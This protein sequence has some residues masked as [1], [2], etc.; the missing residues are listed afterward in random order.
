MV[1]SSLKYASQIK[2]ENQTMKSSATERNELV[3]LSG[4]RDVQDLLIQARDVVR[5]IAE[6]P[7]LAGRRMEPYFW[8]DEDVNWRHDY[9]FQEKIRRPSDPDIAIAVFI[10]GERL[11]QPLPQS[12]SLP[13]EIDLPEAVRHGTLHPNA[14][15]PL[16]GT[17]FEYL[18]WR[19][20]NH[21]R[22]EADKPALA[23]FVYFLGPAQ[24]IPRT[25]RTRPGDRQWGFKRWYQSY[26]NAR[27]IGE[28][29]ED[30]RRKEWRRQVGWLAAFFDHFIR[31]EDPNQAECKPYFV[32]EDV[33]AF[34]DRFR[35]H[36]EAEMGL[37]VKW[38]WRESL[39]GL[40]R[41]EIEHRPVF[42]GRREK[43]SEVIKEL[44]RQDV[45]EGP[46]ASVRL[47]GSSGSGKS[48]FLRAEL[49]AGLREG[50]FTHHGIFSAF[51]VTPR[52]LLDA[53]G[54]AGDI[55]ISLARAIS[56]RDVLPA[57]DSR[58]AN[59]THLLTGLA[60]DRQN[61]VLCHRTQASLARFKED[62]WKQ[63][64]DPP[65]A[66]L[67]ICLDQVEEALDE[68]ADE[69]PR[70]PIW[71]RLFRT[72][73]S[74]HQSGWVWTVF[75]L[76]I[77]RRVLWEHLRD[78]AKT[79]REVTIYSPD[80]DQLGRIIDNIGAITGLPL[81]A[82]MRNRLVHEAMEFR[83]TPDARF[84]EDP[85]SAAL[86]L[87]S[88]AL[89]YYFEK[90][91]RESK[92]AATRP[93]RPKEDFSKKSEANPDSS[94]KEIG[95][96]G[97]G[98]VIEELGEEAWK[99]SLG[100]K[101]AGS[102]DPPL[103]KILHRLVAMSSGT[104]RKT[105]LT[106]PAEVFSGQETN[107]LIQA[108]VDRRLALR[109]RQGDVRLV[110][111]VVLT[112]WGRARDWVDREQVNL[113]ALAKFVADAKKWRDSKPD[114][115]ELFLERSPGWLPQ[116]A[117]LFL[118]WRDRL[119][120]VPVGDEKGSGGFS[121]A[122][123]LRTSLLRNYN[124]DEDAP[125]EKNGSTI[126]SF[127]AASG[128]RELLESYLEKAGGDT[129]HFERGNWTALA[130][131]V[132][133]GQGEL[134]SWLLECGG[135]PKH[136]MKNDWTLL[137]LAAQQGHRDIAALL[138]EQGVDVNALDS[139]R[140]SPLHLVAR[141]GNIDMSKL[142][143]EKGGKLDVRSNFQYTPLHLATQAGHDSVARILI[144]AEADI[145]AALSNDWTPLHIAAQNDHDSTVRLLIELG[146]KVNA[147][148]FFDWRPDERVKI[149]SNKDWTPLHV[150]AE[151]GHSRVMRALLECGADAE[152]STD[153][154]QTPFHIAAE[155]GHEN[156]VDALIDHN[157][158]LEAPDSAGRTPFHL[159]L[160]EGQ[161]AVAHLLIARGT[162]VDAILS[163]GLTPLLSA[164]R[165][166]NEQDTRFLL[167]HKAGVD[168]CSQDGWRPSHF[169]AAKGYETITRLLLD[170][171]AQIDSRAQDGV[172]PLH[173]ACL[174]GHEA[175]ARL[176]IKRGS[177]YDAIDQAG[178]TPL[179]M[180][181]QNGH[182]SI[183]KVLI[184]R[185]AK[186]NMRD[187]RGWM[188][189]HLAA[190]NGYFDLAST[191]LDRGA[192]LE[193]ISRLPPLTP[194]QA[195][196]ETGQE[197]VVGLLLERG[198]DYR[199]PSESKGP[200]LALAIKNAQYGVA[201]RLLDAGA[202]PSVTDN[203]ENGLWTLLATN[204]SLKVRNLGNDKNEIKLAGRLKNAGIEPPKGLFK[205]TRLQHILASEAIPLVE[206][207]SVDMGARGENEQASD[208]VK[209]QEERRGNWR[210]IIQYPWAQVKPDVRSWLADR[211]NPIDGTF[212]LDSERTQFELS[213]LP[214]YNNL[215]ILRLTDLTWPDND[216]MIFYLF[217]DQ[218]NLYR[219]NGTS[220]PVHEVNGKGHISLNEQNVLDYL[221]FFGFFVR[222]DE[223]PF[224]I[225]ENPR[226]P[227]IPSGI[228][229]VT[230]SVLKGMA[231]PA[232]LE[233]SDE[234][235]RFLCDAVVWYANSL[236]IANFA[237]QPGGMIEMSDDE[238]IA[239]DL[240]YHIR[241]IRLT[242][243]S[244][245]SKPQSPRAPA[246]LPP[247]HKKQRTEPIWEHTLENP[248]GEN[249]QAT[250]RHIFHYPWK[251]LKPDLIPR[252]VKQLTPIDGMLEINPERTRLE[253]SRLPFY[254]NIQII[255][256]LDPSWPDK[257][258]VVY[259]LI[260]DRWELYRLNGTS[261]PIH[262]VNKGH[263]KLNEENALA[264]L[265]FFCFFVRGEDGP[266]YVI[267]RPDDS[268]I[269]AD[270]PA[271]TRTVILDNSRPSALN[272]VDEQGHILCDAV[273]WYSDALFSANFAIQ[274]S[275]MMEMIDDTPI[276]GDLKSRIHAPLGYKA[277][278]RAD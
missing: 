274:P 76:P 256:L 195:A 138:I 187:K 193:A 78:W 118:H 37:G 63:R 60:E 97:L 79:S 70:A 11:G 52:E 165:A 277:R 72:L 188:P 114:K 106:A 46:G 54:E 261:P 55:T 196:V 64:T 112:H 174:C 102:L 147:R 213:P 8:Q 163:D 6:A 123:Y 17:L 65:R 110:H 265:Y 73:W 49:V 56:A 23:G 9:E 116:G 12:F 240:K 58:E 232:S 4:S 105:L 89:Y 137:H 10:F 237:I 130:G 276:V 235:G 68:I 219:L 215:Q 19:Q 32:I 136:L 103:D 33:E 221:Y 86:P 25:D 257:D 125:S 82:T 211:L 2:R 203:E 238:P 264:Y 180:A 247:P 210:N 115:R 53:M 272:G 22:R 259:Y 170:H 16:T 217:D 246:N 75:G 51:V 87:I 191:L 244:R 57:L 183:A 124:P 77:D 190:Q 59:I 209:E 156:A 39:R 267:E 145:G 234:K 248:S 151:K 182:E 194:L 242:H 205:D 189:L 154:G 207:L 160:A 3:F 122:D 24:K 218:W 85:V 91:E 13:P 198:A 5:Q 92:E 48:S 30:L 20:E 208:M 113:V 171:G 15:I 107:R 36:L 99:E 161:K 181:V 197:K 18:D 132:W 253:L 14:K 117:Y 157:A 129:D 172:I 131:A 223:G 109:N 236:F 260:D 83:K 1:K 268:L 168:A 230:L 128:D 200:P 21:R 42:F 95:M 126:V 239:S 43:A 184:S 61:Q 258:L 270:I 177:D 142:L 185:G 167:E 176:L 202:D 175:L 7:A 90:R 146:A 152:A 224:Y 243:S 108:L 88:Q 169:A 241:D 29:E 100:E 204:W 155:K 271:Q 149:R 250:W 173:L 199:G 192:E 186:V 71:Y 178:M 269:P 67:V 252:L 133:G 278:D 153:K 140:W 273:V 263:I 275:G 139:L 98:R 158:S 222:G 162:S 135:N 134:V 104:S 150:A 179:H 28:E 74:L 144:D 143:L 231:R 34:P 228:D 96:P 41:Y 44:V 255:R 93:T 251:Q 94:K 69:K 254:E 201:L 159:A 45:E 262:Q 166:G 120:D 50:V 214:F 111:E 66:R 245:L 81:S 127:A 27:G 141:N 38:P 226:D 80:G 227:L 47:Q 84:P 121:T 119:E 101:G 26:V 40:Q 206:G 266:F 225:F 233:G 62:L 164:V 148:A 229:P 216:L 220:P 212:E 249:D 31:N 35:Q